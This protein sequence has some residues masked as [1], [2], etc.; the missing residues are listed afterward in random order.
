[1]RASLRMRVSTRIYIIIVLYFS[2]L[3]TIK[4]QSSFNIVTDSLLSD[5]QHVHFDS[6][7][8]LEYKK[9]S[10][11]NYER[12]AKYEENI[13]RKLL[14]KLLRWASDMSGIKFSW[15]FL[16]IIKY[17][18]LGLGIF[19]IIKF[20]LNTRLG[21]VLRKNEERIEDIESELIDADMSA[22]DLDILIQEAEERKAF[23]LAIRFRYLKIL[24]MMDDLEII[25]WKSGK[26]NS[27]F[28][29]EIQQEARREKF[30]TLMHLYEY[31]WYGEFEISEAENYGHNKRAFENFEQ[32]LSVG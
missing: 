12:E 18:I 16:N 30:T 20:F 24:R 2:L 13:I 28:R 17:L 29:K 14:Y 7:R 4:A 22:K 19:L 15:N 27:E 21:K 10:I 25:E 8:I 3:G 32:N 26:T 1:M 23:R 6:L 11:Y 5:S 9:N 31:V